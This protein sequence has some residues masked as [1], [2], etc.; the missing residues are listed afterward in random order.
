MPTNFSTKGG[1]VTRGETYAKL[2]W[3][4]R[5]AQDQCYVMAHLHNTE[6]GN[7]MDKLLAKGWLGMGE[8]MKMQIYQVTE[9]AKSKLQ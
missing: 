2:L 1:M 7:D 8:L 3:H 6:T 4:L 5:E 9:L